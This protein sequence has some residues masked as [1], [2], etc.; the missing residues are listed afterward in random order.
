MVSINYL[1]LAGF[2]TTSPTIFNVFCGIEAFD[3]T[4]IG[5]LNGAA[6]AAL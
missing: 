5:L 4:T 3:V 2:A 1:L 6:T